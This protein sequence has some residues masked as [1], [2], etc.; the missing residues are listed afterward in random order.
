MAI[1]KLLAFELSINKTFAQENALFFFSINAIKKAKV[2][3][4]GA[5]A[6]TTR[7]YSPT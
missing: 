3:A 1:K 7:A 2:E 6:L 5:S 4:R